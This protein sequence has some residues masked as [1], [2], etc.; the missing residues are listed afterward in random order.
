M[1]RLVI[2]NYRPEVNSPG[3]RL[4]SSRCR[5][6]LRKHTPCIQTA[7]FPCQNQTP[8]LLCCR[9]PGHRAFRSWG[10]WAGRCGTSARHR[11]FV[12]G[13]G[14]FS[15]ARYGRRRRSTQRD[16]VQF[17]AAAKVRCDTREV[18]G[19]RQ[20]PVSNSRRSTNPNEVVFDNGSSIYSWLTAVGRRAAA[21]PES[22]SRS[23]GYRSSG[24]PP[25]TAVG[26]HARRKLSLM[27]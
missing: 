18:R 11:F 21:H 17:R 25:K 20:P 22:V 2:S 27:M 6:R 10:I 19:F 23:A 13:T 14:P 26:Y 7:P 4:S 24:Q 5:I 16:S 8:M 3:S 9:A 1:S 12:F 15:M